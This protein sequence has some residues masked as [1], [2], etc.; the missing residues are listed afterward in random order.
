MRI[1]KSPHNWESQDKVK[2]IF[3]DVKEKLPDMDWRSRKNK[4]AEG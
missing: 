1:K 2:K 3:F 4:N